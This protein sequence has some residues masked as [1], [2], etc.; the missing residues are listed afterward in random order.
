M[1]S[2]LMERFLTAFMPPA[3]RSYR[4]IDEYRHAFAEMFNDAELE[5]YIKAVGLKGPFNVEQLRENWPDENFDQTLK[6]CLDK[7]IVRIY[8][9]GTESR[10]YVAGTMYE[11]H[12]AYLRD[13]AANK[14]FSDA[15]IYRA[16][17]DY[18]LEAANVGAGGAKIPT[19]NHLK[20]YKI[21]LDPDQTK[22]IQL[23]VDIQDRR[24]V[25]STNDV[26]E[27]I[28]HQTAFALAPCTCRIAGETRE[29]YHCH[30]KADC[31]YFNEIALHYTAI[32]LAREI[33]AEEAVA[34]VT[35]A[36]K[37]GL[38]HLT[39]NVRDKAFVLCNCCSCCCMVL[40]SVQRG[41]IHSL[42]S[43][44]YQPAYNMSE[45]IQC[46]SCARICP[47]QAIEL[48][49]DTVRID[50][51]KCIGCGNCATHC[52]NDA[53]TLILRENQADLESKFEHFD[54]LNRAGS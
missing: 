50:A 18:I 9:D 5:M 52:P 29:G 53:L 19:E 47:V 4:K 24:R 2:E 41:E 34:Y 39:E 30:A 44:K 31:I 22:R 20:N 15:P 48:V 16:I 51:A 26:I 42:M 36:G 8:H 12:G 13:S 40:K 1:N 32:K 17:A 7:F 25:E 43:S 35:E 11:V 45:C 38:V 49:E 33:T 46:G 14:K 21:I 54:E 23:G 27:L 10:K 3:A 37:K 6:N 28:K